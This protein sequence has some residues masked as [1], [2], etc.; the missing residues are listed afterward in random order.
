MSKIAVMSPDKLIQW[1]SISL[2]QSFG[3]VSGLPW[4]QRL[5]MSA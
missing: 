1:V 3:F 4:P 2:P 5:T